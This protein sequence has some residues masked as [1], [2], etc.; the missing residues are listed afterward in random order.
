MSSA[1]PLPRT[2][3]YSL[4]VPAWISPDV[5]VVAVMIVLPFWGVCLARRYGPAGGVASGKPPNWGLKRMGG[6][7]QL[8]LEE[9]VLVGVGGGRS[10][11]GHAE[12][13]E[14]VAEVPVDRLVGHEQL[15]GD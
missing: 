2:S 7:T 6:S 8:R 5:V 14:D 11:R 15:A 4:V 12:L 3:W 10:P 13:G 9:P 1:G